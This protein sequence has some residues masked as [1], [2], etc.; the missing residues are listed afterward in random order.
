MFGLGL[1][2]CLIILI[3]AVLLFGSKAIGRLG[4]SLI[5]S[6]RSV[7]DEFKE[8]YDKGSSKGD[9]SGGGESK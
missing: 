1:G 7:G 6:V 8:G 5:D 9:A 2:E 3:A 4:R